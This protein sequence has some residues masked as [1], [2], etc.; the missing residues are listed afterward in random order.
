MPRS[1]WSNWRAL[2]PDPNAPSRGEER[3]ALARQHDWGTL[4]ELVARTMAQRLGPPYAEQ[5]S[6]ALGGAVIPVLNS[7]S[8]RR[9]RAFK[10]TRKKQQCRGRE[11]ARARS[12]DTRTQQQA[13]AKG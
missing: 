4:V 6:Q 13:C 8:R 3:Q 1:G 10:L 11:E 5:L 12:A 7:L 9:D 2:R